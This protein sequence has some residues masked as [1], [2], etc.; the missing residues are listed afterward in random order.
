[1]ENVRLMTSMKGSD[2][3]LFIERIM[4][5]FNSIGYAV[6]YQYMNA[7]DYGTPQC[8]DRV[9]VVGTD[10][11]I[12]RRYKFPTPTHT[13]NAHIDLTS[14]V[15]EP[16]RTFR[17]AVADL[18]Q[19]ESGKKSA[20]PL[21]WTVSHPYHVIE[22]LKDVPEGKSAHENENP[23]LR[24][25]SGFNTTY[26][27]LVWDEPCSTIST[28]FSMIS[29]CRNVHPASTRSITIR[30]ATRSQSFPDSFAFFGKWGDIRRVIGNAVPPLLAKAIADSI[31]S[32]FFTTDD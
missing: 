29:G 31:Y 26:K 2:G 19:L 21:H 13:D 11:S 25:P 10:T 15:N 12:A 30:E 24:P 14:C 23:A 20:D 27:R 9:I 1:M 22:W 8:R 6:E 32:Q 3:N 4:D 7:Q 5:G 17:D 28:N 16:I 18:P